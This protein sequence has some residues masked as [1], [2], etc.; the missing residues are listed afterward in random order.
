MNPPPVATNVVINE[1]DADTPSTDMAESSVRRR[2]QHAT[3]R[4]GRSLF[5]GNGDVSYAAF[6]LDGRFTNASGYFTLG[7]AATLEL[8]WYSPNFL[9]NGA[10]AVALTPP[11]VA[12][13][14][15][16][17]RHDDE[18]ADAVVYCTD[19]ADAGLPSC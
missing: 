1:V 6:D 19:D 12:T 18:S 10:D 4:P 13:F 9:Q 11:T 3:R 15:R 17:Q 14:K 5:N 8:T 7:N 16:H 2:R